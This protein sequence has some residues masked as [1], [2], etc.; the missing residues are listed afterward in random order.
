MGEMK[1]L[2]SEGYEE[3][4]TGDLRLY[5]SYSISPTI[6]NS[7]HDTMASLLRSLNML[8]VL[9]QNDFVFIYQ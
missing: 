9:R 7:L 4:E 8:G 5:I 3:Y 1:I 6:Q 2:L